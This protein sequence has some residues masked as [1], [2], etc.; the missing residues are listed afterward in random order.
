M[1]D[2]QSKILEEITSNLIQPGEMKVLST[3]RS[4]K[5]YHTKFSTE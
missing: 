5:D 2:P 1:T 3:G 4:R